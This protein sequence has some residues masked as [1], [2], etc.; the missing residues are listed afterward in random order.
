M[1]LLILLMLTS[2]SVFKSQ[3]QIVN[4]QSADDRMRLVGV[5]YGEDDKV[6]RLTHRK[7]DGTFEVTFKVKDKK[8]PKTETFSGWWGANVDILFTSIKFEYKN[9][10]KIPYFTAYKPRDYAYRILELD[11]EKIVTDH[12]GEGGKSL[13][14]RVPEIFKMP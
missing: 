4:I 2:C 10:Q 11:V 13:N 3:K 8:N 6:Q 9:G 12:E 5:W 1:K 7:S 14:K